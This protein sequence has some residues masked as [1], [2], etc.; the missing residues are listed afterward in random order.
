LFGRSGFFKV[1]WAQEYQVLSIAQGGGGL[2]DLRRKGEWNEVEVS[3]PNLVSQAEI[4][5][6]LGHNTAQLQPQLTRQLL[7]VALI[8]LIELVQNRIIAYA[9]AEAYL[10]N[11]YSAII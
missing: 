10:N 1:R 11:K 2:G 9:E 7:F 4:W 3:R 5:R 8:G 6:V